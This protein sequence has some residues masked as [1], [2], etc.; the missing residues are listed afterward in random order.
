MSWAEERIQAVKEMLDRLLMELKELERRRDELLSEMEK[1]KAVEGCL[2][3]KAVRNP[4]GQVYHYWYL[5]VR[6]GD[7]LKSIYLGKDVPEHVLK[8]ISDRKRLKSLKKELDE[9]CERITKIC[10]VLSKVEQALS[11]L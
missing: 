1:L 10:R 11:Q 2:E 6:E 3:Y 4:A 8:G 5:R 9:V 7:K